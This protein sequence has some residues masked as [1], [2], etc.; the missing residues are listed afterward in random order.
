MNR[1]MSDRISSRCRHVHTRRILQSIVRETKARARTR[2]RLSC[3]HRTFSFILSMLNRRRHHVELKV[4]LTCR[5]TVISTEC[6]VGIILSIVIYFVCL[7]VRRIMPVY[8]LFLFFF[9]FFFLAVFRQRTATKSTRTLRQLSLGLSSN[10]IRHSILS[11]T[12]DTRTRNERQV[13][14]EQSEKTTA[15]KENEFGLNDTRTD[16]RTSAKA[17]GI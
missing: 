15:D 5:V 10:K 4:R 2:S 17:H 7:V 3:A 1:F 11:L 6:F 8:S 12:D 9:F 13:T 14:N 16:E